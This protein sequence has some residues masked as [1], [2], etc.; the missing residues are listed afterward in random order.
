M[1]LSTIILTKNEENTIIDCIDSVLFSEEIIVIDDESRD[2]TLEIVRN[3][4][5]KKIKIYKRV[6]QD[7]FSAQRNFG[8]DK[9][10]GEWIFFVDGDEIVSEDLAREIQEVV[11]IENNKYSGYLIK[12]IDYL[13][14]TV[15]IH[16]ETG[17]FKILRLAKKTS[18]KFFGVVHERWKV[19]GKVGVLENFLIHHPHRTIYEFLQKINYYTSLRSMELFEKK[20]RVSIL[21]IIFYP[22]GKFIINY[23]LKHGFK[24]GNAGAVMALMMSFHSFLVRVKL[25][26]LWQRN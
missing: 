10:K 3:L 1:K 14:G 5:N 6:L 4:E 13:L 16:G 25:W 11:H 15:L 23:L 21:G 18:G 19:K 9:A 7:D 12:R 26:G 24:D 2:R 17:N 22:F 8:I 20:T